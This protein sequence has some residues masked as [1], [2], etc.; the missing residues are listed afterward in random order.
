MSATQ[1]QN[2][3]YD[4]I[5]LIEFTGLLEPDCLYSLYFCGVEENGFE[6]LD[7][8]I[9]SED[10]RIIFFNSPDQLGAALSYAIPRDQAAVE[11]I[12]KINPE[13]IRMFTEDTID[14]IL[15]N[16]VDEY[17]YIIDLLNML[18][19]YSNVFS[20]LIPEKYTGHKGLIGEL[21]DFTTFDR[22]IGEFFKTSPT[23]ARQDCVDAIYWHLGVLFA[24][25]TF[26]K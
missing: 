10:K 2:E 3:Y 25:S 7:R 22:N 16:D 9:V 17:N 21:A 15:H 24:N 26:I 6:E 14:R 20:K 4:S 1:I 23:N 13:P 19:D 18:F 5:R 12:Q 11:D 8:P